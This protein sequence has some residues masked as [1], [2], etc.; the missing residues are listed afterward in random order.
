MTRQHLSIKTDTDKR[1]KQILI[2]YISKGTPGQTPQTKT[3]PAKVKRT[4]SIFLTLWAGILCFK[5]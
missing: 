5:F 1:N 3:V 2:T 4:V